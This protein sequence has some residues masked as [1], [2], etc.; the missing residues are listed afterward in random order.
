MIT[1]TYSDT[2]WVTPGPCYILALALEPDIQTPTTQFL[3][4]MLHQRSHPEVDVYLFCSA[5]S[6]FQAFYLAQE[7]IKLF[8][9]KNS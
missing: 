2:P 4:S 5:L 3:L 6:R 9:K 7:Q 1:G 8:P